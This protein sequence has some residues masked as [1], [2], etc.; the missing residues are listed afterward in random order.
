MAWTERYVALTDYRPENRSVVVA[1]S[2][3]RRGCFL[4]VERIGRK[5]KSMTACFVNDIDHF[6]AMPHHAAP[7]PRCVWSRR[8]RDLFLMS[9]HGFSPMLG[10]R[11]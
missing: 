10:S 11:R 1:P 6:A 5:R 8:F 3:P 7:R 4:N 2:L 9:L